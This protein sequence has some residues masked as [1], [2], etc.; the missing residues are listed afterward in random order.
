MLIGGTE[1]GAMPFQK[2]LTQLTKKTSLRRPELIHFWDPFLSLK[3]DP[4]DVMVQVQ[5]QVRALLL[6]PSQCAYTVLPLQGTGI[7]VT[8]GSAHLFLQS[9][10][11]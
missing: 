7:T 8:N 5:A 4:V 2:H 10:V 3:C 6:G 11:R 1:H 9:P